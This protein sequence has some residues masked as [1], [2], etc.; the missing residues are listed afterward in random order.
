MAAEEGAWPRSA[1]QTR[2]LHSMGGEIGG[3]LQ[4][5][6]ASFGLDIDKLT[7]GAFTHFAEYGT[8]EY[9]A[10]TSIINRLWRG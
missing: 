10:R 4:F 1:A 3:R 2:S 9:K 6:D 5:I 8:M 7:G